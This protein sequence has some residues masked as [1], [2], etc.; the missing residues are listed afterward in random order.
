[1]KQLSFETMGGAWSGPPKRAS[2]PLLRTFGPGPEGAKCKTCANFALK[3]GCA[4]T[5]FK[6][7]L[8]GNTNGPA[9]D[10]RANWLAC[11]KWE[12]A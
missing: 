3:G 11:K 2:N 6:C 5:Y 12:K 9:T 4:R 7:K 8:F 1:M 10:W